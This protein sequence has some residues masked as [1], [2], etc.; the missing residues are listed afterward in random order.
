MKKILKS[1][2]QFVTVTLGIIFLTS[3]SID[4]TDTLRGS[5]TA[6]G[7]FAKNLTGTTC[8][9]GMVMVDTASGGFCIDAY[10]VSPGVDCIIKN[11]GSTV[12]TANNI[13]QKDCLPSSVS[14]AL[15]WTAVARPQAAE[16]CAKAGKRLPSAEE[17]F[18]AAL[19]TTDGPLCN[20]DGSLQETGSF[21]ECVSGS[22]A[23]DMI[24]NVWEHTQETIED[25]MYQGRML[26]S[27]GYV[28][29]VDAGGV[30][31]ETA[32]DPSVLYHDDYFWA[33]DKG[34]FT[35]IRGGFYGSGTDG[36]VYTAHAQTDQNFASAAIGFRCVK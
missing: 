35:L 3:F 13:S 2:L 21:E 26:P 22:G 9:S 29:M 12:D 25:G 18:L 24:G 33:K 16:L 23:F 5:Q 19:G 28:S 7:I 30:A 6:L 31:L 1:S 8:P 14:D 4:A 34:Y 20:I 27:E 32:V 17:W 15:P 36:G 10:E 11:P